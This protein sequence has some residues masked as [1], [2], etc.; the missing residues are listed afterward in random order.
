MSRGH[1]IGLGSLPGAG[2]GALVEQLEARGVHHLHVGTIVRQAAEHNGFVPEDET[3]EAYLPFWREHA[4]RHGNDWLARI[5]FATASDLKSPV[6]LDGVRI[7][8][9]ANAIKGA[10]NATMVWLDGDLPVLAQRLLDRG[11][12]EDAGVQTVEDH[13]TAL[14]AQLDS[15]GEFDLGGVRELAEISL[16]PTVQIEDLE[17]RQLYNGR[18][19][20]NL[21]DLCNLL[22]PKSY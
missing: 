19:A 1:V 2:K 12:I 22:P 15:R 3:R 20:D 7:K 10:K 14:Q 9:D 21:L 16:F 18:I 11:R 17:Q 4:S 5:A 6:V 13:I 8:A